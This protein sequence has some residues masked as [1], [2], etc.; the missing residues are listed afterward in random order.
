MATRSTSTSARAA[1]SAWPSAPA[2]RSRWSPRRSEER[3]ALRLERPR[4]GATGDHDDRARGGGHHTGGDA[5]QHGALDRAIPAGTE[6]EQVDVARALGQDLG[7]LAME[8]QR[9][10]RD[11]LRDA[12]PGVLVD[13]F[14]LL[15]PELAVLLGS[16]GREEAAKDVVGG[17][18]H[19]Q[20]LQRGIRSLC[21]VGGGREGAPGLR[22]AIDR[23]PDATEPRLSIGVA[24]RCDRDAAPDPGQQRGAE[25]ADQHTAGPAM[26]G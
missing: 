23:D 14:P 21:E 25:R 26:A 3:S 10:H 13:T 2:G 20:D 12:T 16:E 22:G 1:A 19:A 9:L 15:L 8:E 6:Q 18:H 11:A 24:A 4:A 17:L 5:A 7:G